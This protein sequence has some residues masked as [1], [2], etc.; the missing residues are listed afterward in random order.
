MRRPYSKMGGSQ[1]D[2][3]ASTRRNMPIKLAISYVFDWVV[4]FA[5]I[6]I[7]T[8]L[9]DIEPNKRPFSLND[10]DISYVPILDTCGPVALRP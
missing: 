9:G 8:V 1:P 4:I 5:A 10:P 7:A 6:G 3:L 2:H